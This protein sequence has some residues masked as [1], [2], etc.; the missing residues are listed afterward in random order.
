FTL[1][2]HF[3]QEDL[4]DYG[5]QPQFLS[6]FDNAIILEDLDAGTLSRIFMEPRDS[7]FRASKNF[8]RRYQIDLDITPDA[9]RKIADEASKSRRIGARALK[10]VFSKILKPFEFDPF[11]HPQVKKVEDGWRLVIDEP[12]VATSVKPALETTR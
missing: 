7:V 11:S 12:L 6:R 2:H 8:F 5:M 9:V 1:T 4:F 10:A 3:K